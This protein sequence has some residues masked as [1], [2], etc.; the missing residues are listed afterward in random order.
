MRI[1]IPI[2]L[3][4]LAAACGST[5]GGGSSGAPQGDG[6]GLLVALIDYR[7]GQRLEL[8]SESHTTRVDLY[9][10]PR[11]DASAKVQEDAIMEGMIEAIEDEGFDDVAQE[12][13]APGGA[14]GVLTLSLIHI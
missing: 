2:L 14:R 11:R 8:R 12:G 13:Q 1:L 5:G 9:S 7:T 10:A 4:S 6:Q 3:L